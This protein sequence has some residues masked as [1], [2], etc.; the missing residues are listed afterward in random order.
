MDLPA[1]LTDAYDRIRASVH[2]VLDDLPAEGLTYRVDDGANTIA[3]LIW[4]LTRVQDDHV[5][6]VAGT[7]QTWTAQ[8][9]QE[10]FGL[11]FSVG[12]TGYGQSPDEVAQVDVS[13]DLLAGYYDAVHEQT[14]RY[15]AGLSEADLDRIVDERWDPPVSLG[16]RLISV[17]DDDLEHV[18]QAAFIKGA[19]LRR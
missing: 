11:P 15:I 13:G 12:A 9:W 4:H 5:A 6:D 8:G 16:V 1:V 2:G 14:L 3:W 10:R 18:G 7:E 19:Y 17:L